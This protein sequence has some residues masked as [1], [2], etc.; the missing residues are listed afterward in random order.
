MGAGGAG[1]MPDFGAMGAGDDDE[2][3]G[4]DAE[5]KEGEDDMPSLESKQPE[6]DR[7]YTKKPTDF[8]L[9]L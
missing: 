6:C 1:G 2:A 9:F 4:D 8:A 5:G 7:R 3:G